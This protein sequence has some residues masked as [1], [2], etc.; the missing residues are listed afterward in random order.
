MAKPNRAKTLKQ[1]EALLVEWGLS[2]Q[3]GVEALREAV[4]KDSAADLA[5]AA[6]LGAIEDPASVAVLQAVEG[7]AT[8]KLVRKEAKRSLYRLE[9]AGLDIP[10]PQQEPP[11][12]APTEVAIDGYVSAI[13]GNGDQLVWLTRSQGGTLYHVFAV[14]NDPAGLKEIDLLETT[15]KQ[16]RS[17]REDLLNEHGVRMVPTDWHY[18]DFLIDRAFR[19]AR[20]QGRSGGGDYPGIRARLTSDPVK[21]HPALIRTLLDADEVAADAKALETSGMLMAEPELRLWVLGH[22]VLGP[23][24]EEWDEIRNSPIVL[25]EPQQHERMAELGDKAADN[26]YGG[27]MKASWV[28]RLEEMAY[29]FYS[30]DRVDQARSALAAAMAL[31]RSDKGGSDVPL[32]KGLAGAC[33]GAH[34]QVHKEQQAEEQKSSL[35]VSPADA[36]RE[37]EAKKRG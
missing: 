34:I 23:Y 7:D 13:D 32:L 15:R 25:T 20:E 36:A 9:Q 29:T 8:D 11:R 26:I 5:I 24:I 17:F 33:L 27:E 10:R 19:W 37:A 4:G 16:L 31:E 1:G 14:L 18:C 28:R 22:D 35:I 6:R 30:T 2:D 3:P 21:E 12:I